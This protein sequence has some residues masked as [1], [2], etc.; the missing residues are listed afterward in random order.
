VVLGAVA[1]G[2][3]P[4][5]LAGADH[6]DGEVAAHVGVHSRQGELEGT[7]PPVVSQLEQRGPALEEL[8][9]ASRRV[10]RIQ[11][12]VAEVHVELL[13]K[14]RRLKPARRQY[15]RIATVMSR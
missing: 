1:A 8:A 6:A 4:E 5:R 11:V 15:S 13:E 10:E 14:R 12:A 7:D 3:H 2:S 9:P